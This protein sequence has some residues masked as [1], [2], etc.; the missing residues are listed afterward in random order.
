MGFSLQCVLLIVKICVIYDV[1]KVSLVRN[2]ESKVLQ[3][4]MLLFAHAR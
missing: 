1:V 4:C 2:V 3:Q